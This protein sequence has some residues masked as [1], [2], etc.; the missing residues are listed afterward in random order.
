MQ[1]IYGTAWE[2]AEQL[3]AYLQQKAEAKLRDHR[4]LGQ[5]LKLFSIQEDAAAANSK[6]RIG[7]LRLDDEEVAM[8]DFTEEE[9]DVVAALFGCNCEFCVNSLRKLRGLSPLELT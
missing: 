3:Q 8:L 4:K 2:T 9:S 5:E 6:P 7:W 1:R